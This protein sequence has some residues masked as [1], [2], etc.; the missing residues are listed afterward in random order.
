MRANS[1][2]LQSQ[3]LAALRSFGILDTPREADFDDIVKLASEICE[4][5]ISVVN[6]IDA[7]RQWFKAE[8]GLGTRETPLATSICSHVILEN[9]FVEIEDTQTD[10]RTADNEL[11]T[12]EDG[13]R[14]YAG[15]LLK[16]DEGLP[17][18]T[19]CVLDTKPRRLNDLQRMAISTLARRVMRE[20]EL[21]KALRQ[22]RTLRDEVDHRVKNSLAMIV[23]NVRLQRSELQRTGD[24]DAAFEAIQRQITAVG[25]VNEAM[26]NADDDDLLDLADYL[27][28]FV[29]RL[30]DTLPP[31]I[32][33]AIESAPL[34][35]S[36]KIANTTGLIVNEFIANTIKHGAANGTSA[37]IRL[38]VSEEG[39][40]LLLVCRNDTA[41]KDD[42]DG[43]GTGIGNRLM[44]ASVAQLGGTL[45]TRAEAG[46]FVLEA[47]MPARLPERRRDD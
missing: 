21:R 31:S 11:C 10:P 38:Q 40:D 18:G 5:P 2:P 28:I 24:T 47:L 22:E 27:G 6:L 42:G 35:V 23:G 26:N 41:P 29:T 39:D 43:A 8:V 30:K 17:I 7:E 46:G 3:R 33:V 45:T 19:L 32:E 20:F 44:E 12:P 15:A 16:T 9:D 13:L 37:T 25:A 34:P 14:F 1:H 36:P 4:T